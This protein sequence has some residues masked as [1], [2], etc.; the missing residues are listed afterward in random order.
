M[1]FFLHLFSFLFAFLLFLLLPL[2]LCFCCLFVCLSEKT[3]MMT[4]PI[5][6]VAL[7]PSAVALPLGNQG[8]PWDSPPSNSP[9]VNPGLMTNPCPASTTAVCLSC[10]DVWSPNCKLTIKLK[11][12]H[13]IKIKGGHP[14][15]L[16][17]HFFHIKGLSVEKI[18]GDRLAKLR[19]FSL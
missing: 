14:G 2:H 1:L 15:I 12:T 17:Q 18:W 9:R 11:K 3:K 16:H 5:S 13:E 10:F 8:R 4:S 6:S 19:N 7:P